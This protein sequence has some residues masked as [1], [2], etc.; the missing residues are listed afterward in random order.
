MPSYEYRC[1]VC[2]TSQ[3]VERSIHAES[4]SPMCC[5]ELASRV[6]EAPPVKFNSTGFYSTDNAKFI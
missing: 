6:F 5:G 1:N 3:V 2:S 4:M